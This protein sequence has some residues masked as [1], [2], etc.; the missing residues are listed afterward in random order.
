MAFTLE[1]RRAQF[2]EVEN[3]LCRSDE[4]TITARRYGTGVESLTIRNS[5]GHLEVLPF[6]GQIIW[7]AVFD[8]ESLRMTSMFEQPR[9]VSRIAETYGCFAFHSGLLA[10]GCPSAEDDHELH[11]E[12][13]CAEMDSAELVIAEDSVI[14]RSHHEYVMGFGHHYR[15][16]PSVT[17]QAGSALFDIALQVENLSA[18]ARMPL[19]YMCHLN[20]R[21]LEG[22]TMTQ[23]LPGE[24]FRLRDSVPAHVAPTPHWERL[25]ERLRSGEISADSLTEA[26]DFDPEIVH[27]ADDLPAG[28]GPLTFRMANSEDFELL[29]RFD[30]A[31]FPV[32]T[33]WILSNPDQQVAAFVLPG[34]SRPEGR[35]AARRR[36]TLIELPAGESAT[37]SVTTGLV[38]AHE[39]ENH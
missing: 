6:L 8:G 24:G 28:S 38:A 36:G 34:T 13:A 4:W 27:F 29:T 14:L 22:A 7:D 5:R 20:Y 35:A 9:K 2:G 19:Q 11:G 16:M 10:A 37:Y 21:F 12:F 33:R 39:R 18:H 3:V 25:T 30:P 17:M 23:S 15:A 32:A 31:Q 1:L 26:E